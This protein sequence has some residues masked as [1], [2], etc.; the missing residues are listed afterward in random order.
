MKKPRIKRGNGPKGTIRASNY[1][2]K[3]LPFLI[4]DFGNRCAYCL[5]ITDL[6]RPHETHVEHFDS[7]LKGLAKHR[8]ENLMLGCSGCNTVKLAKFSVNPY[9]REQRL[10]NC[11]EE[12]EFPDHIR[13]N[14]EG[15][16]IHQTAAG[17]YHIESL[18]LNDNSLLKKR[19][20]R[21]E[22]VIE[23]IKLRRQAVFYRGSMD[24]DS[25]Q[26]LIETCNHVLKGLSD[27]IPLIT[28][29]GPVVCTAE[30]LDALNL[31]TRSKDSPAV[32]GF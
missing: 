17:Y 30:Y 12:S 14:Y 3:A 32:A 5:E 15:R 20:Y 13:E 6:R 9:N 19:A 23:A 4:K 11:T 16:W 8:Y 1:R 27:A 31:K 10:L 22:A 18:N 29:D 28:D 2:K 21:R 7:H 26:S 25:L 24:T